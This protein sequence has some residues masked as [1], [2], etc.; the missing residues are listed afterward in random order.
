MSLSIQNIRKL[1]TK[2]DSLFVHKFLG[3]LVLLNYVTRYSLWFIFHKMYLNNRF[4]IFCILIHGLLSW[5]SLIFHI[6][7]VRNLSKPMIYPENRLHTIIFTTRSVVC[8]VLF[9]NKY[10]FMYNIATCYATM[11]CADIVTAVYKKD[12]HG[13]T[14]RNIPFDGAFTEENQRQI[15][16]MSSSMQIGA[17]TFMLGDI[18]TAFSPMFAIQI[19]SFLQTMVRKSIIDSRI[20]HIGYSYALLINI[21]FYVRHNQIYDFMIIQPIMYHIYTRIFFKY[22]VN[23][24]IA[25]TSMFSLYSI[26]KIYAADEVSLFFIQRQND[27]LYHIGKIMIAAYIVY[28]MLYWNKN[29]LEIAVDF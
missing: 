10:H 25:W 20:W 15:T 9:Y 19:A 18:D 7:G 16:L 13:T 1:N 24:Y 8:C 12:R 23:K 26:Y 14:I 2:E 4:G 11:L 27:S 5:S 21:F 28:N 29:V 22:R 17:T 3:G 6:S